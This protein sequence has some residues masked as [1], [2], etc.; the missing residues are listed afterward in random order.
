MSLAEF[1]VRVVCDAM[2]ARILAIEPKRITMV[3][4]FTC[5]DLS[6]FS[7]FHT[8]LKTRVSA[9]RKTYVTPGQLMALDLPYVNGLRRTTVAV[10]DTGLLAP[11]KTKLAELGDLIGVPKLEIPAPYSITNMK[12]FLAEQPEAFKDYAI[13]DAEIA[14]RYALY[15]YGF[16][17]SLGITSRVATIA[18]AGAAMFRNQ[19]P[20]KQC[21]LQFLGQD[22]GPRSEK[23][24]VWRPNSTIRSMTAAAADAFHGGMNSCYYVGYSPIGRQVVD[25]DLCGAYST[26]LA[27]IFW[28][29]W[30]NARHTVLL[31]DLA[32]VDE[33][34]TVAQV[35][36]KFRPDT[37]TPCLPIRSEQSAW[38]S[39]PVGWREF[40]LRP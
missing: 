16:F 26:A 13:R 18:S 7:D 20:V 35:R 12:R 34:M 11:E 39:I 9:I 14:V 27:A 2:K 31:D 1:L 15:V 6:M 17:K 8:G 33:A 21:R 30:E 40:L 19:I 29:D 23:R 10:I 4:H 28:A 38:S 3:G 22:A 36:F 32:V 24:K 5:A 37:L 25:V